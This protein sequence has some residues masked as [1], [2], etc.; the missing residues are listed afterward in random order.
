MARSAIFVALFAVLTPL[1]GAAQVPKGY[2]SLFGDYFPNQQ[3]TT[4]LRGRVFVEE[5]LE[6][7]PRI[8]IDLAGFAEGLLSHRVTADGGRRV[9][10][11]ILGVQEA[12]VGIS[13]RRADL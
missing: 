2:V 11:A 10:D 13:G 12:S 3:N 7:N 6:P 5:R 1:P 4:E 9:T 8:S